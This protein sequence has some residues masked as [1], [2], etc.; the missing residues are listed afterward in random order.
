[1]GTEAGSVRRLVWIGF[2]TER[3]WQ[4]F[5]IFKGPTESNQSMYVALNE[6]VISV[7]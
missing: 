5:T 7:Y 2:F 3:A 1:M 4:I 6:N